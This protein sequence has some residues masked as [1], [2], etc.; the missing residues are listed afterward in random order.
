MKI[1]DGFKLE[2]NAL[3]TTEDFFTGIECEIESNHGFQT[4]PNFNTTEDGSLR[5]YGYEYIS[6]PMKKKPLLT[7]FQ[8]LQATIKLNDRKEAFSPR[9]STHVHVN[10]RSLTIEQVQTIVFLYALYEEF[11]FSI[12]DPS[13]RGN[14]HC[15]PLTE[16]F[17]PSIYRTGLYNLYKKWH[18]YTALNILPLGKHGTLEFRHLQGTDD[19]VLLEEWIST[20]N[21]LWELG[22]HLTITPENLCSVPT[23]K[24]WFKEIFKDSPK[25]RALENTV[26]N[27]IKNSLL[28]VKLATIGM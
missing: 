26:P 1:F 21:N 13:R 15:V 16:T 9:T 20:L 3:N 17:L 6:I 28:D 7:A 27:V 8:Y 23:I 22:K 18:K 2:E 11:F 12:V 25:I 24:L 5:N 14:I 10:C 4:F 19:S